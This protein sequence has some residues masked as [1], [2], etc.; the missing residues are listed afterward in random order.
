MG[1]AMGRATCGM[2]LVAF[3]LL[4]QAR[5]QSPVA[6]SPYAADQP[7]VAY[8]PPGPAGD[9]WTAPPPWPDDSRPRRLP[10]V[11]LPEEPPVA[12]PRPAKRGGGSPFGGS[13]GPGYGVEWFPAQPVRQQDLDFQLV[14]QNVSAGAPIYRGDWGTAVLTVGVQNTHFFTDAVLPETGRAFPD[15]LWNVKFGLTYIRKF[16][17]GSTLGI[18]SSVGSASDRP[19]ASA[20]ELNFNLIS[21]LR[22][23]AANERDAWMLG[24][25]YSPTGSLNFPIPILAYEWN[26]SESFQM[27]L[28]VP[29]SMT[30][31]PRED[32]TLKLAYV[33]LT[34][35]SVILTHDLTER[36]H[37]YGGYRSM[38]ESYFLSDRAAQEDR[39]FSI[40]Q[41]VVTGIRWDVGKYGA[42]DLS[43]GYAFDR[44]YGEG[45]NQGGP[46]HDEVE[47]EP[48]A[49]LGLDFRLVF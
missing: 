36:W 22:K 25:M 10:E 4:G 2:L 21:F 42:L 15:D 43:G 41:R 11:V 47:I 27:N 16:E 24:V 37:L 45:E 18:I 19:F 31:H 6:C 23:P 40:Q 34:N 48:G 5:A 13:G 7:P 1:Q 32:W 49:F 12:E 39:F 35:G 44:R 17:S 30:W 3:V 33:P 20:D 28:G 26:R 46:W 8:L 38:A 29:L 14:D 9:Y